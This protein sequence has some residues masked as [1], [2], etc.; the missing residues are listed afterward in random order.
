MSNSCGGAYL[1]Q[2]VEIHVLLFSC[3]SRFEMLLLHRRISVLD[4]W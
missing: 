4:V 2:V 1:L 3:K